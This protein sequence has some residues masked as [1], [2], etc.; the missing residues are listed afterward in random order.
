MN[1]GTLPLFRFED[2]KFPK[3]R[4]AGRSAAS[5]A[6]AQATIDL[7]RAKQQLVWP[8]TL[9]P[10]TITGDR[11]GEQWCEASVAARR[12]SNAFPSACDSGCD[13]TTP[14]GFPP[15]LIAGYQSP[16]LRSFSPF[17]PIERQL[18]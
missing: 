14:R 16:C 4:G 1:C 10:A 15:L 12:C 17:L 13:G 7:C 11:I 18:S 6:R 3:S 9:T 2:A 5:K 8:V